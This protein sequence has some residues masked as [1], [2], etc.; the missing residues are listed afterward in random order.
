MDVRRTGRRL[1]IGIVATFAALYLGSRGNV[2]R[3]RLLRDAGFNV[4]A[5]EYRGY[6]ASAHVGAASEDGLFHDAEGALAW[7]T[8]SLKVPRSR[9]VAYGWSLGSGPATRLAASA[10]L[11]ALV[12]EGAFT[13]LPDVGAG[14][15]PWVPV[16]WIMRTRFD[17]ASRARELRAPW[18]V[19]HGQRDSEIPF[20][21]G[22]ALAAMA[23]GARLVPLAADHDDGVLAD[24]AVALDA[25]RRL[26]ASVAPPH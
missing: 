18:L 19:L 20:A 25:L 11:G 17:N 24:P 23:P 15:Y 8:D 6:G 22:R 3:Y 10:G 9:I 2:A 26:A 13:S 7:L 12:T 16:R 4:L 5:V 14:M 1:I 21:H